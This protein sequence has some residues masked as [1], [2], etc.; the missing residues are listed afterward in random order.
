LFDRTGLDYPGALSFLDR[1]LNREAVAG[2]YDGLSLD[3]MHRLMAVLDDPQHAYRVIH[4]TGTNGKG[5]VGRMAS[6][7]LKESG[8]A[9]GTYASPHLQ[10]LNER[11]SWN[12]E[13][14]DDDTLAST[15]S[16]LADLEPVAGVEASYFELVT[17]AALSWF[18]EIAVDVAVVEVGLLGRFDATNVV[19]ADVAVITNIGRDHTDGVGDWRRAIAAEKAGIVK[20]GS[21]LVLG[22]SDPALRPVFEAEP[23]AGTWVRGDDFDLEADREAVGGRVVDIRTPGGVIDDIFLPVHGRHQADNAAIATTA[24]E[25]F[26][27][28]ELDADLV[29]DAFAGLTLP[30]RFEVVGRSPLVVIDGA[31]NPAGAA[32]VAETLARD[33]DTPGRLI[34]V[35][36]LLGERDVDEMLDAFDVGRADFVIACT[37]ASPR[38]VPA[39]LIADAARRLA[40]RADVE[41][42]SSVADAVER[43]RVLADDDDVVLVS[44]SLYVAGA[45]RTHLVR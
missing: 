8:L 21:F 26:F 7:L 11:L 23:H 20:P 27:A 10:R 36:G 29:R 35:I 14:I 5:S 25:A 6:A 9:V 12:L 44:G 15:V 19:D 33:F 34:V 39:H 13:P 32:A 31:H 1:H 30:G 38:A 24:V 40:P 16:R 41:I 18:A 37:A 42:V 22:E 3:T 17:A 4:I 28:R 43:A 45:A 2:K